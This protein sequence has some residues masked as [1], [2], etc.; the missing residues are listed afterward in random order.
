MLLVGVALLGANRGQLGAT[1]RIVGCLREC[2]FDVGGGRIDC[3]KRVMRL[4]ASKHNLGIVA[5][6]L[7]RLTRGQRIEKYW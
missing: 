1:Q 5:L 4:A 3:A 2:A 7:E 6:Q